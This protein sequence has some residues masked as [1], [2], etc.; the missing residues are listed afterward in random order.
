MQS[1]E[2]VGL[3][4]REFV[5]PGPE[6][7]VHIH[8]SY[9]GGIPHYLSFNIYY[10]TH[11]FYPGRNDTT[12]DSIRFLNLIVLV[13]GNRPPPGIYQKV[14]RIVFVNATAS[15][16]TSLN[17]SGICRRKC[18]YILIIILC[19]DYYYLF[20]LVFYLLECV[21]LK[22]TSKRYLCCPLHSCEQ[23]HL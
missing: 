7:D 23:W 18:I 17:L 11:R 19:F 14:E 12:P 8:L 15:L 20:L 16:N 22:V 9:L 3:F 6:G 21:Y 4:Y 2:K 13:C 10:I 1:Q 5:S